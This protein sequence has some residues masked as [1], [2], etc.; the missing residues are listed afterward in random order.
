MEADVI[1]VGAGAAGCVLAARLSEDPKRRVLLLEAGENWRTA[2]RP[3][4]M[5]S[6]NPFNLLNP[7]HLQQRFLWADL[8]ARRTI[9]QEPRQYRRGS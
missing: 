1:V 5:A 8:A 3:A 7:P 2:E 9:R 4:E 6:P